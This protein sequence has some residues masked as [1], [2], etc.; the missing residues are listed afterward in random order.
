VA[1]KSSSGTILALGSREIQAVGDNESLTD[2][3]GGKERSDNSDDVATRVN[4]VASRKLN[5]D[6]DQLLG[7]GWVL[8]NTCICPARAARG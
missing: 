7:I 4:A 1:K 3:N 8:C 5:Y 6:K 2:D